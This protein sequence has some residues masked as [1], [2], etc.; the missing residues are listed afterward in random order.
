MLNYKF[1]IKHLKITLNKESPETTQ[2]IRFCRPFFL[3]EGG[4]GK[5]N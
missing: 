5:K 1:I 2:M 3:L 4:K